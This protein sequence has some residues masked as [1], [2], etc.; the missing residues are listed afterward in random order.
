MARL[1]SLLRFESRLSRVDY[2]HA[3]LT[4]SIVAA[5]SWCLGLFAILAV[6]AWGAVLMIPMPLSLLGSVAIAVRRLH[7]RG[8]SGWW[9]LPLVVVPV[10]IALGLSAQTASAASPGLILLASVVNLGLSIWGWV[11]IGFLRGRAEANRY[12]E[13]T[14]GP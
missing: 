9:V 4:L 3:Y 10:L 14:R 11:E 5:V 1:L 13:V 2:W 7:D 6:G 12:G 8:K